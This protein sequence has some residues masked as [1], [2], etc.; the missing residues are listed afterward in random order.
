VFDNRLLL[1]ASADEFV[2][3]PASPVPTGRQIVRVVVTTRQVVAG[4]RA[5]SMA[6]ASVFEID[7][8][9]TGSWS[10]HFV[11]DDQDPTHTEPASR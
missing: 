11:H 10:R 2:H 8:V 3:G 1:V 9:P 4:L 6:D 5:S 7:Q